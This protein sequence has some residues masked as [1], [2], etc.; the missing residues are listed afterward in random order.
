MENKNKNQNQKNEIK[1]QNETSMRNVKKNEF[2][3]RNSRG[4]R[5]QLG[6]FAKGELRSGGRIISNMVKSEVFSV[7]G[8][9]TARNASAIP[10]VAATSITLHTFKRLE[11]RSDFVLKEKYG[12]NVEQAMDR[13]STLNKEIRDLGG[14]SVSGNLK[15]DI[16]GTKE[17][18]SRANLTTGY[19]KAKELARKNRHNPELSKRYK[20]LADMYK[21]QKNNP[22]MNKERRRQRK[23]LKQR[24]RRAIVSPLRRT[25]QSVDGVGNV[26]A[27]AHVVRICKTTLRHSATTVKRVVLMPVKM[28]NWVEHRRYVARLKWLRKN[29]DSN[30]LKTQKKALQKGMRNEK[31]KRRVSKRQNKLERKANLKRKYNPR[32]RFRDWRAKKGLNWRTRMREWNPFRRGKNAVKRKAKNALKKVAIKAWKGLASLGAKL[33]AALGSNPVG[34]IILLVIIIIFIIIVI[35][36]VIFS[37]M[38]SSRNVAQDIPYVKREVILRTLDEAADA[39]EE[40]SHNIEQDFDRVAKRQEVYIGKRSSK[41]RLPHNYAAVISYVQE[42]YGGDLSNI[43]DS[44]IEGMVQNVFYSSNIVTSKTLGTSTEKVKVSHRNPKTGKK[45]T[46]YENR[47]YRKGCVVWTSYGVE[48]LAGINISSTIQGS[49][50]AA[51][52]TRGSSITIPKVYQGVI[53][54]TSAALENAPMDGKNGHKRWDPASPQH[55]LNAI[56]TKKGQK[57]TKDGYAVLY[58]RYIVAMTSTFG[59]IGDYVDI[60][61]KKGSK[62]KTLSF[63]IGDHKSQQ[64]GDHD[65]NPANKW[66]HHKG[67][68]MLEFWARRGD[69]A[70]DPLAAL[71]IPN[72]NGTG[73]RPVKA[74]RGLENVLT[75]KLDANGKLIKPSA[76]KAKKRIK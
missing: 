53:I 11:G 32:A 58:G 34:W 71:K 6:D 31:H 43:D 17:Y 35:I 44:E 5:S 36:M 1:K 50:N 2:V 45:E 59:D 29:A 25:F 10:A 51:P 57:F 4:V 19:K 18:F 67:A 56:W 74:Y 14:Q 65:H 46:K 12:L 21:A 41:D 33:L 20:E 75:S 73:W 68:E 76:K 66:G 37:N 22:L 60:E 8:M 72:P 24:R 28:R 15:L 9:D 64:Y 16:S 69:R 27:I 26:I 47:K 62:T 40:D 3:A 55:D 30:K 42:Y 61:F 70:A 63:I 38:S 52:M 48:K 39:V 13:V 7:D 54:G 23:R 49:Q